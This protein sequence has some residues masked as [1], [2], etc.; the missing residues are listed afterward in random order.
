MFE[1]HVFTRLHGRQRCMA[2]T[3]QRV[4]DCSVELLNSF[5]IHCS[6]HLVELQSLIGTLQFACKVVVPGRTFLQQAIN[7]TL[8][9]SASYLARTVH[10]STV[11]LY[12]AAVGRPQDG[13]CFG[14]F[15]TDPTLLFFVFAW[16]DALPRMHQWR[17]SLHNDFP[18]LLTLIQ[19]STCCLAVSS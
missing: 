10:H 7:L 18:K 3:A 1:E 9:Y 8:V 14:G 6:V 19:S 5:K 2:A 4:D 11:K 17:L 16:G 15:L 12:L 13:L